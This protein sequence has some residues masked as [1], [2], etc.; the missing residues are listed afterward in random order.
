MQDGK[1]M[2]YDALCE[3]AARAVSKSSYNQTQLANELGV[4]TGA[5]SRA[6][7]ESGPKFSRLQRRVL[8]R[9][10]PYQIEKHVVFRAKS[11][12]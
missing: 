1:E 4:S 10:T 12:D 5:M 9:L 2:D 6:L 8:E 3:E 11:D 7:S